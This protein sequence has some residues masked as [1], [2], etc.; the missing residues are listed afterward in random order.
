MASPDVATPIAAIAHGR[1]LFVRHRGRIFPGRWRDQ[2]GR[3]GAAPA[4]PGR[5]QSGAW[6]SGCNRNAAVADRGFDA[7]ACRHEYR[8]RGTHSPSPHSGEGR[9]AAWVCDSRRRHSSDCG[10]VEGRPDG[11]GPLRCDH[12]RPRRGRKTRHA[13]RHACARRIAERR[14]S[15]RRDVPDAALSATVHRAVDVLAVLAVGIDRADG[16]PARG[17]R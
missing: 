15:P 8:E 12:A 3:A 5:R 14:G 1:Q 2:I 16:L 7:A 9:S 10:L 17:L 6:R 4:I 11:G 13:V